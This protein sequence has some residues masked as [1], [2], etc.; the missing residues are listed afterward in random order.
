MAFLPNFQ[1]EK[2]FMQ[3]NWITLYL[4]VWILIALSAGV[5]FGIYEYGLRK[6]Q[7]EVWVVFLFFGVPACC[8]LIDP[9]VVG[10]QPYAIRRFVPIIFPLFFLLSLSGWNAF[11]TYPFKHHRYLQKMSLVAL[12][13]LVGSTFFHCSAF[14]R[15]QPLFTDIISQIHSMAEKIPSNALVIVPDSNAGWHLQMPLQYIVGRDTLL[16]PLDTMPNKEFEQV[17]YD[18]LRRQLAKGRPV[19]VLLNSGSPPAAVLSRKFSLAFR[20][21]G[22]LSFAYVPLVTDQFPGRTTVAVIDYIGFALGSAECSP[23]GGVIN[24]GDPKQDLPCLFYG[25][26]DP[27]WNGQGPFRWTNGNAGLTLPFPCSN[28]PYE[29]TIRVGF[30]GPEGARLRISLDGSELFNQTIGPG[31]WSGVFKVDRNLTQERAFVELS[32]DTFV[33]RK[34]VEGSIDD[35]T[36]GIAVHTIGFSAKD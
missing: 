19:F 26:Y 1:P 34:L 18:Y 15:E 22:R 35:R 7:P 25:F 24:I 17:M 33:P 14:L 5:L 31:E 36:L 30:T 2:F 32:S 16:L 12:V 20:F 4:P 13:S 11:L 21:E 3:L 29:L 10:F 23:S 6:R 27:E 9:I 28:P 8:Y